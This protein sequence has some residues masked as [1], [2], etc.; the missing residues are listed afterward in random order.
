MHGEGA[1]GDLLAG[2]GDVDHM[3][4]LQHGPVGAAEHAVP[5][6]LQNDL[7]RVPPAVGVHDDHTHV[8]GASPWGGRGHE[9]RG[10]RS[11]DRPDCNVESFFPGSQ[12]DQVST[13]LYC[14]FG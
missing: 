13:R 14:G 7:H 9:K 4:P 8:P 5:F 10:T 2:E 6:V 3:G 11:C 1:P 12:Q